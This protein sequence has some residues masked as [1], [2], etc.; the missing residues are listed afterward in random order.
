MTTTRQPRHRD[1]KIAETVSSQ[2]GRGELVTASDA[3]LL[4]VHYSYLSGLLRARST[5][6][7]GSA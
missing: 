5:L 3:T 1:G 7:A 4:A 2:P 6:A